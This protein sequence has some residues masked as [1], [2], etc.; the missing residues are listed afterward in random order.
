M[1]ND[2][3]CVPVV[4]VRLEHDSWVPTIEWANDHVPTGQSEEAIQAIVDVLEVLTEA[5][6]S[7]SMAS[8]VRNLSVRVESVS[9]SPMLVEGSEE[10]VHIAITNQLVVTAIEEDP[11]TT[12]QDGVPGSVLIARLLD[13]IRV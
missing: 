12:P 9:K 10:P 7:S 4:T 11:G 6:P 5:P 13:A 2:E 1:W 8:S 3:R